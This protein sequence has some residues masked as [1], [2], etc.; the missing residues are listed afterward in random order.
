MS[1][2]LTRGSTSAPKSG[3]SKTLA[4]WLALFGGA[5]GIHRFYLHGAK[6]WPAWMHPWPTLLGLVGVARMHNLG[7]DDLLSW[8]LIPVLGVMLTLGMVSAIVIG[9]TPDERWAQRFGVRDGGQMQPTAWGPIFGV[10]LALFLGGAVLMGTIAF[11]GQ[12]YFE[13]QELNSPMPS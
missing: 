8:L 6:D 10:I 12:K 4:T 7:Q 13:W 1:E 5:L 3:K 2:T 9:L 11:S